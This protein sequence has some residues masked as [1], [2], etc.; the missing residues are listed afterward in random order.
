MRNIQDLLGYKSPNLGED[1]TASQN[2]TAAR[3]GLSECEEVLYW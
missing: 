1:T 3:V 2:E